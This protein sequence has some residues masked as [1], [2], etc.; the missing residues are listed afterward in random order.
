MDLLAYNFILG[1]L[2]I[3]LSTIGFIAEQHLTCSTQSKTHA[4]V[5]G[6]EGILVI[7]ALRRQNWCKFKADQS[8]IVRSCLIN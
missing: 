1:L 7:A 4:K 2:F 8:Y 6:D 5:K 3:F